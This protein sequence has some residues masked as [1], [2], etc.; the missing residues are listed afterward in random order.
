[1]LFSR[2]IVT[3]AMIT[4]RADVVATFILI[5]WKKIGMNWEDCIR[6]AIT[7]G[8]TKDLMTINYHQDFLPIDGWENT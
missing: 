3:S 2:K 8:T 5:P 4:F 1:M 6:V 7:C